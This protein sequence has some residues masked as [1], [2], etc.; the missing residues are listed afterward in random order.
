MKAGRSK[1][2]KAV[3]ASRKS[4]LKIGANGVKNSS[5]KTNKLDYKARGCSEELL[6]D[7]EN[8]HSPFKEPS[9]DT[10]LT[11]LREALEVDLHPGQTLSSSAKIKLQL[12]PVNEV[13]RKG[14]EKD[15]HNPYLE[16]TLSGRKKISSVLRHIE[17]KWGSSST[18]KGEP[19]LFPYNRLKNLS[20]HKRWTIND[21]DTTAAAVYA[22]VGNPAIFRL[23]YGWFRIQEPTPVGISSMPIPCG[24]SVQSGGTETGGTANLESLCDERDKIEATAEYKATEVGN[25]TSE[26]VAQKMDN[27]SAD[28]LDN[29]PKESCS[30]QPPSMQWVDSLD[31]ISIGGLLSEAS[32]MGKFDSKFFGSNATNQTSRL[33]SDSLDAFITSQISHPPVSTPSTILDAE[34]AC[35]EF[36]LQ[37]LSS[38]ADVQTTSGTK[39]DYSVANSLGVSSNLLK[40]PCTDK[41]DDQDGFSQ[42]PLSEK[43][44]TD[45]LLSS[46]LFDG[47]RSLGLTGIKWNDSLG[48]FD[49]GM[50]IKKCIGGDSVSIG[51]FVK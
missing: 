26:I 5:M 6:S 39:T 11:I 32:F 43:T 12:F 9:D 13:I 38:P 48:P 28:P 46:H 27:E 33:I 34:V 17:K 30:L 29:E 1:D 8:Q 2:D 3:K 4:A 41:V 25:I 45:S 31:N 21:S 23:K 24:S 47:E 22:A 36:A 20:D 18:A 7:K 37:K 19:M 44:Q 14:L 40:L 35:H 50:P 49:L 10:F 15:G 42:N 51:K 16:L